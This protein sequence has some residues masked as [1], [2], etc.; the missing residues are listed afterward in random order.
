MAL[1]VQLTVLVAYFP[2]GKAAMPL[3]SDAPGRLGTVS[4]EPTGRTHMTATC[5][6]ARP[7]LVEDWLS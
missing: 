2:R 3:G 5:S 7:A 1:T 4:A 6:I